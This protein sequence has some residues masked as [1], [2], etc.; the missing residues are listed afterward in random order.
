MINLDNSF[1][2]R[3]FAPI[4]F[5]F[6]LIN[7]EKTRLKMNQTE[8]I[9]GRYRYFAFISYKREDEEWA[10][11]LQH[12]L[13]HYKL[14]SNLN[15]RTDLPREIRPVFKDTSD[16]TPGNLPEQI[17]EALSLSKYLIVVCSPRSAQSEWVNK[18]VETFI[19]MGRIEQV[20]PFII[21]G[22]A[23]AKQ[24]AEE[25]FPLAF[26]QLPA[27]QEI[28]GANI[29]EMGRDAAVI[30]VIAYMFDVKFD[31][32]WQRNEREKKRHRNIVIAAVSAFVLA[33]LGVTGWIWHQN[34]E[35]ERSNQR[36][37]E[38]RNRV[39][40]EKAQALIS[41]GD[42]YLARILVLEALNTGPYVPELEFA[43]RKASQFDNA[44][45]R[46]HTEEVM[47]VAYS[48]DG[49]YIASASQDH[50]VR[51]WDVKTG[52]C[53]QVFEG[54]DDIVSCVIF[55]PDGEQVISGSY[56]S[57]IR[58]WDVETGRCLD[59][60]NDDLAGIGGLMFCS[61]RNTLISYLLEGTYDI[62]LWDYANRECIRKISCDGGRTIVNPDGKLYAYV[63]FG[64]DIYTWHIC[65]VE[66]G[67]EISCLRGLKDWSQIAFSHDGKTIVTGGELYDNIICIWDVASGECLYKTD[68]ID[69]ST[70]YSIE[71]S[72]DDKTILAAYGGHSYGNQNVIRI[73]R[74]D[75]F[76]NWIFDNELKGHSSH[77]YDATFSPDMLR[78]ASA[79][80]DK[81]VRIWDVGIGD[82]Q[83]ALS[84]DILISGMISS[85]G[86]LMAIISDEDDSMHLWTEQGTA[87]IEG[88]P[89]TT[90][91]FSPNGKEFASA[92]IEGVV[93]VWSAKTCECIRTMEGHEDEVY[94]VAYSP[95]GKLIASASADKTL[96]LWD[97]STGE[98]LEIL[99]DY[100]D[101]VL[102]VAFSPD[103]N[104][105][106]SSSADATIRIWNVKSEEI[107]R[108][109]DEHT[110]PVCS[111]DFSADGKYILSASLDSTMRLWNAETGTFI[112]QIGQNNAMVY[113]A[114]FS[115]DGSKVISIFSDDDVI[116][117]WDVESGKCLQ[118]LE[119]TYVVHDGRGYDI[120]S[121]SFS[122]DGT[123]II[124]F[125]HEGPT[126]VYIWN[127]PPFEDLID[128][129]RERFINRTLSPEECQKYYL[130]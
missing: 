2:Y 91:A 70:I 19:K 49:K 81:T 8:L 95:N 121:A 79:S 55:S 106:V 52:E 100:D 11:W 90:P 101:N 116:S 1:N 86:K 92:A 6:L 83:K 35:L 18:E 66:T 102:S 63:S 94:A 115:P 51:L 84:V 61:D 122:P 39:V 64:S 23:F 14:P 40:A 60:L 7:N 44:V 120:M 68:N 67:E 26:R 48:P 126:N 97:A 96:R 88:M 119:S 103:G 82:T 65:D 109:I 4:R 41:D 12:K 110:G 53:L 93:G 57:T 43:L 59:T 113:S 36:M 98:C 9:E 104:R 73:W 3:N 125:F 42:N 58:I 46:G 5:H 85:D 10:K 114:R 37:M 80:A 25:C 118:T 111:V 54:H 72:P 108:I 29:N 71:F 62:V 75:D 45:L 87:P 112:K 123:E 99:D 127:F 117:V 69:E 13:E 28:L 130:E 105:L 34:V 38:N 50:T 24:S 31:S 128:E 56:D 30:K 22:S 15:G 89:C 76:E 74:K 124:G 47:D 27:E 32:L 129:N 17:H 77:V 33:I 21:E 16:L 78:I 20:I 107:E